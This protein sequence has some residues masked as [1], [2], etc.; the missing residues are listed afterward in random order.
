MIA[1]GHPTHPYTIGL[2]GAVPSIE[3]DE[4]RLHPIHG[5]PPEPTNLPEGCK[6][7]P[8]CPKAC[9]KCCSGEIANVEI[10]S[11][12]FVKCILAGKETE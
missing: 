8:R 4:E 9:E 3:G 6:F 12:H 11:G 10:E 1:P 5:L 7:H 2:F